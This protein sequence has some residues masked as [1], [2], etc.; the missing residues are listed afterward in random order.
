VLR[1][2]STGTH[3]VR[4]AKLSDAHTGHCCASCTSSQSRHTRATRSCILAV[5]DKRTGG[6]FRSILKAPMLQLILA[7]V[8]MLLVPA[9]D[10]PDAEDWSRF[11]GPNGSGI[12]ASTQLPAEFGPDKNMVWKTALPFGHSSPALTRDRIVLTAARGDR[13]V[14]ICLDRANGKMLWEREAPRPRVEKLDTRNGPA[15]PTPATDGA[16]IYVFFADF[17]L[18]SYDLDGRERWRVPLGPFNNLYG[19]GSSP[20]L[21]DDL[22]VLTCDQNTGSYIIAVSQRDGSL[23]WK[24]PRPEAHSGHST[25]ILYRPGNGPAQVIVPGSFLLTAYTADSGARLWW[26]GGLSF[27]LKSTPVVRGDTLYINGFGTPQNQPGAHPAIESFDQIARQ[28][29]DSAG[30]IRLA[31]MPNG[32]SRSWIDLDANGEISASEWDYYR[33]AMA[34]DNG[35]LAIRLGGTGD[36]TASHVRW[37]YHKSV[38]QLPSPLVYR[39]VLYMVND[40][41]IV[42]A[43]DP[44]SGTELGQGRLKGAIDHYY[45]S[46]VAADGKV[47]MAS[48]TGKVVVLPPDGTLEPI[49]VN[50]LADDIYATPAISGGRIYIRTRSWL[51]CFG[52][53][54]TKDTKDTKGKG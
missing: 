21:V 30:V 34:S 23:R 26:V 17:G 51:Y 12:S 20:V 7:M 46:P 24:T 35:M 15:G 22:V 16:S 42:T 6:R 4:N 48:E 27:E 18:L 14:T 10:A 40:G 37:K 33:A 25:P 38:P 32:A 47:F 36:M 5:Y 13:L 8:F 50:D 41:G 28:Y 43:L 39:N 52:L 11:R 9:A 29:G 3:R 19:M 45:A 49:A 2:S 53:Q 31:S 44:E 54:D 1:R